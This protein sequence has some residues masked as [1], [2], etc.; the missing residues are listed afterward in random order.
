MSWF[1]ILKNQIASTKGKQFQLDFSEPMVEEEEDECK[2]KLIA[3]LKKVE[4]MAGFRYETIDKETVDFGVPYDIQEKE[5]FGNFNIN[6]G[7]SIEKIEKELDE[8]KACSIIKVILEAEKHY[9]LLPFKPFNSVINTKDTAYII[10]R[11]IAVVYFSNVP[12]IEPQKPFSTFYIDL[13]LGR[14]MTTFNVSFASGSHKTIFD[15]IRRELS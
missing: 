1:D 6:Y 8:E 4:T 11:I 7:S 10:D 2:R 14:S 3:F 13:D 9:T 15:Y 12:L 5:L